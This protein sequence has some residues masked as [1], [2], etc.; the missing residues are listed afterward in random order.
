MTN[1]KRGKALIGALA[2]DLEDCEKRAAAEAERTSTHKTLKAV[3]T[4]ASHVWFSWFVY[5]AI[6]S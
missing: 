4:K 6:T 5:E 1:T 2:S 3:L